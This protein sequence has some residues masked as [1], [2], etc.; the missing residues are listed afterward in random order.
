MP[1]PLV[2][3][4]IPTHNRLEYLKEAIASIK[5]QICKDWELIV[6]DD[7]SSDGTWQ[8]L[9]ELNDDRIR[10]FR[11]SKN[12]ERSA[13]RNRGLSEAKGQFIMFLD[14]DD[15]L[16]SDALIK[17]VKPLN[18][19]PKLV[20]AV[21]ARRRFKEGVYGVRIEHPQIPIKRIIWP[22]LLTGWVAVSG[23]NLYRTAL[24][25][26]IGGYNTQLNRAEDRELWLRVGRLGQV[27][28]VPA[29]TVEIRT[30]S[31]QQHSKPDEVITRHENIYQEFINSLPPEEHQRGK[32]IRE[33]VHLSQKADTYY[34]KGNYKS[35]LT[36]YLKACQIAP[37]LAVSPLTGSRLL[38]GIAKSL[39]API[40]RK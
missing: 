10:V 2:S 23:Q 30:H 11:Q 4:V 5:D 18:K 3:V 25:R 15:R 39:L 22:D 12:S 31:G 36:C 32:R 29:I 27:I 34:S 17:L 40:R 28:L 38:R 33:S 8:Y 19:N 37:E 7:A 13:A 16:R 6:I 9:S 35:A 26:K 21:G 1:H 20:A 14:D 24:L